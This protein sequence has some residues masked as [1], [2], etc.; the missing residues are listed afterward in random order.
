M[1]AITEP[2]ATDSRS[3]ELVEATA[4]LAAADKATRG[5]VFTNPEVV[6][7]MLELIGYTDDRDLTGLRVLE[8]SFGEGNF[9]LPVIDRLLASWQV[10]HPDSEPYHVLGGCLRGVEL[11]RETARATKQKVIGRLQESGI[12]KKTARALADTWL[13]QD[14]FLAAPLGGSFTHVLGNPPYVRQER[15]APAL[16]TFY[17]GRYKTVYDRADLYIPFIER[18]LTLLGPG[19]RLS[20]IC[21]DRWTKNRYGRKLRQFV[22]EGYGLEH[23][24]DMVGTSAFKTEVAAYTSVVTL[25]KGRAATTRVAK[26]PRLERESL[27]ELAAQLNGSVNAEQN[28][29]EVIRDVVSGDAPWLLD[30]APQLG[31]IRALEEAFIPLEEAGA[32]V[33][34]GVASGCDRVYLAP[35]DELGVEPERKLPLAM[36]QDLVGGQFCW[37][38]KGIVNPFE[39]SGQLANPEYYP[40]FAAF[41]EA[42]KTII[43]S[44]H[45]ARKYPE[46]WFRT[47]DRIDPRLTHAPKLLIPDIRNEPTVVFDAGTAYPHHNLYWVTSKTWDLRALQAVL[48]SDVA[49]LFVGAYSVKLRGGWLR[50]QA[51]NLRRI[52]VPAWEALS[53][54]TRETLIALGDT[55]E[56]AALNAAVFKLYGLDAKDIDLLSSRFV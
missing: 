17:R 14:D 50:F 29:V 40:K 9:L 54:P 18:G 7:F 5:A 23:Y 24:V 32:K 8:P 30:C 38:G 12:G 51:Q 15:V 25:V 46:A 27:K 3:R 10:H 55:G 43:E 52:C 48:R 39:A 41:L 33:G 16:L 45:I 31:L 36:A 47:I 37:G 35:L 1:K 28:R 21:S 13:L 4:L 26:R 22:A 6:T 34:I 11:H 49:R 44:R 20:F 2:L 19:G 56:R 42:N 53:E